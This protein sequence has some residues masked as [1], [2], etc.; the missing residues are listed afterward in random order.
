MKCLQ[1]KHYQDTEKRKCQVKVSHYEIYFWPYKISNYKVDNSDHILDTNW[2][3]RDVITDVHIK[4][5]ATC[6]RWNFTLR[7][8]IHHIFYKLDLRKVFQKKTVAPPISM[9]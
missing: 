6:H 4:I 7:K 9:F 5:N 8:V 1:C 3:N 2:G